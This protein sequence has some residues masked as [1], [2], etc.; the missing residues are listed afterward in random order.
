MARS[1]IALFLLAAH[2][3]GCAF[4]PEP[5]CSTQAIQAGGA[6]RQTADVDECGLFPLD[7]NRWAAGCT[8]IAGRVISEP[9]CGVVERLRCPNETYVVL[10]ATYCED[11]I[12]ITGPG[13]CRTALVQRSQAV[14]C[15]DDADGELIEFPTN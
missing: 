12:E 15:S 8:H 5:S 9:G 1:I 10:A 14:E 2:S 11:R 13:G 4:D 7:F 3:I 6:W